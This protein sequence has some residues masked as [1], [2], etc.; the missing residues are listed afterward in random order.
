MLVISLK[1]ILINAR[2]ESVQMRHHYLGVEHLFIAMLQIQ[3]GITASII[4][5]YGFAP[6]YVIDAIRRKTDKGTNQRLWAGFPYTPR[7]DVVLDIT[8]DLAMD[9]HL[10]E[11]TE[12]ELLIAILSEHDS[13]PIRVLQ[14]LG[15]NL[16]AA[17]L[18]AIGY[19]PKRE[20]QTPDINVMFAETYD[21][22]QPIQREQLFVL[23][24]MFV[25]HKMI[26]IEQRLT[27]FSGALVL[28]VTPINADDHEDAPVVVKIHE[29]DAI[30]DEVQRF[31]AH[32]KSSLPLQTAR[33]EDS[34]VKPE[35]SELAGIKY[36]LVA[37]SGGIPM[38]LRHRVKASGPMELGKLLEKELY[39]QFK[40]TW[41][42]QKRPFRFQAWKEYDWLM[43]PLLTL[44]F[45]PD[46]DQ[47]EMPLVVKVP[48]NRAKLKTKLTELKFGDDV[49][50]ENFTVQKVDQQNNILKL[51][52]GFGSEADKRAY[53][54]EMRGVNGHSKSFY[55]GEVVERLAG[56]VWKTRADLMLDAVRDL[57]PDFE[58][59]DRWISLDE[60]QLPNPLLAY[61]NLLDRHI[62]GSMSKIHG[63]LHLGNILVG[64]NN[65]IWLIDFGHTRDGHTLFDWATLEVSLLGD[66]LMS[67]FDSEWATV[68]N[69]VKYLVAMESGHAID[70]ASEQI[71]MLLGSIKALRNIVRECLSTEDNWYEYYIALA[72]CAL[73]GITWKTMSLGGRRMLYLM[74]AMAIFEMNRKYLNTALETPSPD[75]TDVLP[76][77]VAT[78]NPKE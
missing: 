59:D 63:D 22:S 49:V 2:Q 13:L 16:K 74:S 1:D 35:N 64:P 50:L 28:V 10:A 34:P 73:R 33:L 76:I 72:L 27:G 17:T 58:P 15:M 25:G 43:P 47:P 12:R 44:D 23:R 57:E 6:E 52:V 51:A 69:V 21:T 26:R 30:L 3:G 4:E 70:G 75:L 9:S 54:I 7:T 36:T 45:I 40:I 68:R 24:R 19:D 67:T 56:T 46:N 55:R 31:E 61:E 32:V 66:A 53:K 60:M 39:A 77:R 5:D 38:D 18:A 37:H 65:S 48:V 29:A 78:P 62:N 41:W 42:Q 20:P 8:T 14:A 11:A 71:T